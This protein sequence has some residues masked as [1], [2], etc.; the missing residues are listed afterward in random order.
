M[1][2]L[3]GPRGSSLAI[4]RR[5]RLAG[6]RFPPQ[7]EGVPLRGLE[8]GE[9]RARDQSGRLAV[10]LL[11]GQL[12]FRVRLGADQEQVVAVARAAQHVQHGLQLGA[13][14]AE[15][16]ALELAY[17]VEARG[18]DGKHGARLLLTVDEL[19]NPLAV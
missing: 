17:E 13:V 19:E 16:A 5:H 14:R 8:A 18:I 7:P 3:T 12:P 15:R 10:R 11:L 9:H 2:M 4:E 6:D 1:A